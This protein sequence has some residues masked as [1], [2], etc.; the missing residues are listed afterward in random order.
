MDAKKFALMSLVQLAGAF[1][2]A[3]VVFLEYY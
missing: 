3:A 2:A 1:L